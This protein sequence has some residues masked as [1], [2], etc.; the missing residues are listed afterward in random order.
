[1]IRGTLAHCTVGLNLHLMPRPSPQPT[2]LLDLLPALRPDP[3]PTVLL[4]FF[5]ALRRIR[6]PRCG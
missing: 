2:L 3:Q 5:P 1:M 6:G 4:N